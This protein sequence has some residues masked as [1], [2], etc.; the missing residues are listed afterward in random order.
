[1]FRGVKIGKGSTIK[2]SIVMQN[3]VILENCFAENVV[4]DKE[5]TLLNDKTVMGQPNYPFIIAKH[6]VV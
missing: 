4:L 6:S 3:S 1:V 2:N 5:V